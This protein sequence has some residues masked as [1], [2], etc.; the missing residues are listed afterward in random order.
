[1]TRGVFAGAVAIAVVACSHGP[2]AVNGPPPV[3]FCAA[4]ASPGI[5][6]T[7]VDS[8]TGH[9]AAFTGL[10]AVAVDGTY[11][12]ST[13]FAIPDSTGTP[14][15]RLAYNRAGT[16]AVIVHADR[17]LPW[18]RSGVQVLPTGVCSLVINVPL[19][20]RLVS[21]GSSGG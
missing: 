11:R 3:A 9:T 19:T 15:L 20:A 8:L 21:A 17:Y 5:S 13:T 12:D 14:Q 4:V 16:Y 18:N 7:V 6:V 1:M 10:Y 2:G